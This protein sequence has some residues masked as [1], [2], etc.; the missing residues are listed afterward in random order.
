MYL[1]CVLVDYLV[2]NKKYDLNIGGNFKFQI[3]VCK[4]VRIYF[5]DVIKVICFTVIF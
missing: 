4:R 5:L 1:N 2:L 3:A